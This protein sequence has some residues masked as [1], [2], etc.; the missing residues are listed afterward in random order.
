MLVRY[1]VVWGYR[2]IKPVNM[3]GVHVL[4]AVTAVAL[5]PVRLRLHLNKSGD[6]PLE[7]KDF[8]LGCE[9]SQALSRL[10]QREANSGFSG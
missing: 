7:G 9:Q 2:L 1:C 4:L 5:L 10:L 3:L 6:G 8:L